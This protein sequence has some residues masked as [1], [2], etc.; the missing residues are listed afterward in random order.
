[1][2]KIITNH[3]NIYIYNQLVYVMPNRVV[4]VSAYRVEVAVQARH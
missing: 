3:N 4:L 2:L 1:M